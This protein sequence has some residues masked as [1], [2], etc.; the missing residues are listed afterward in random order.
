MVGWWLGEDKLI[1]LSTYLELSP[2]NPNNRPQTPY[3][4]RLLDVVNEENEENLDD[5]SICEGP[6]GEVPGR[7]ALRPLMIRHP[8]ISQGVTEDADVHEAL[9]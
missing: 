6:W 4:V 7:L 8:T 5:Y 3:G 9:A 1:A 2:G